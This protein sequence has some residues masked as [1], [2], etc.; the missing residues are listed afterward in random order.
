MPATHNVVRRVV[1]LVPVL[2]VAACAAVGSSTPPDKQAQLDA[3]EST[4]VAASAANSANGVTKGEGSGPPTGPSDTGVI[5]VPH[6]AAGAGTIFETSEPAPGSDAVIANAW[7]EKK[8]TGDFVSVFAGR[9]AL[10]QTDGLLLVTHG[11]PGDLRRFDAPSRHGALRIVGALGE[12][13]D[14]VAAD[15]Y[16]YTFDVATLA[17]R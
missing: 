16:R 9:D 5:L 13:L 8:S 14:L 17:F 4:L 3:R 2:L 11:M 10:D 15:G 7:F 12:V 1:V 6:V